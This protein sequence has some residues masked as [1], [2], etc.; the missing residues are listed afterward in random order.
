MNF[1][2]ILYDSLLLFTSRH[3]TLTTIVIYLVFTTGW[4]Q[5]WKT[6]KIWKIQVANHLE[7]S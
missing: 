7:I 1:D 5:S 2:D 3:S 6:Q 4:P